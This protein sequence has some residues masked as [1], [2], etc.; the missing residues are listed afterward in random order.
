MVARKL[1]LTKAEKH[2][3]NFMMDTQLTKR[4]SG[5]RTSSGPLASGQETGQGRA[6]QR[7]RGPDPC[8]RVA[9]WAASPTKSPHGFDHLTVESHVWWRVHRL[10]RWPGTS[11]PAGDGIRKGRGLLSFFC[12]FFKCIYLTPLY[13]ECGART[14]DPEIKRLVLL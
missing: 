5:T 6:S 2:V 12:L 3:H 7:G 10:P 8:E 1:E 14:C 9:F 4:V 13:I 11:H